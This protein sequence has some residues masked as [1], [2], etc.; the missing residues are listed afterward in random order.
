MLTELDCLDRL[1]TDIGDRRAHVV[2]LPLNSLLGDLF[3]EMLL[4]SKLDIF[5]VSRVLRHQPA[6]HEG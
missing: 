4:L 1:V 3:F 6:V 5:K 2:P